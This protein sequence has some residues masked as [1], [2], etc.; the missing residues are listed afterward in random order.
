MAVGM[1]LRKGEP[2]RKYNLLKV[3][4]A[5]SVL[6]T[7]S[8]SET[9]TTVETVAAP[10]NKITGTLDIRPSVTPNK[11]DWFTENTANIG[12]QFTK[13]TSIRYEHYFNTTLSGLGTGL[14]L[15]SEGSYAGATFN[16]LWANKESGWSFGYNPRVYLPTK[17]G[18]ADAGMM[19][20]TRQYFNFTKKFSESF[21]MVFSEVPILHF[22]NR[23]A[24]VGKTGLAANPAFENRIYVNFQFALASKWSLEIPIL[25]KNIYYSTA[26]GA[27]KSNSWETQLI[28][29]YP[30]LDYAVNSNLTLGV[31]YY[32]ENMLGQGLGDSLG[33]GA[34][35]MVIR[36]T[37]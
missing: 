23:A 19:A 29:Y 1:T 10:V 32:S 35:Q 34:A 4:F 26:A 12:Y 18:W 21:T 24:S 11:A 33:G 20:T 15:T 9:Q 6:C 3:G 8:F 13:D 31:S 37:L 2:M 7:L 25:L 28:L 17:A 5:F 14:G 36:A 16:N 22:Y 27:A 30:E